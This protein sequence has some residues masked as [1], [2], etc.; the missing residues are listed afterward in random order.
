MSTVKDVKGHSY[1]VGK[2]NAMQQFHVVRRLAT[3]LAGVA[4]QLQGL[5]KEDVAARMPGLLPALAERLATLDDATAEYVLMTCLAVAER[6]QSGGGWAQVVAE[7]QL[8]FQDIDMP[9]MLTL[10]GH[11]LME[12]LAGFFGDLS[13]VFPAGARTPSS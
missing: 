12:N 10:V 13:G 11:V 9:A 1:K 2:L 8:M 6:K 5:P 3:L 7:G 4:D